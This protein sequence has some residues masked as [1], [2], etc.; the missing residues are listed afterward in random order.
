MTMYS[1]ASI[2][3]TAILLPLIGSAAVYL[4]FYIRLRLKPTFIGIDDWLILSS[5]IFVWAQ[6][7]MQVA[8]A[9]IGGLG[10]DNEYTVDLRIKKVSHA[11]LIIEKITYT[12]IKLS[13]LWFFRRIFLHQ[14]RFRIANDILIVLVTLW[15][16]AFFFTFVFLGGDINSPSQSWASLWFGITD[17]VSDVAILALPY[18]CIREL[19]MSKR[20]K[21]GVI[22]IFLLGTL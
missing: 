14:K 3:V 6:G 18:P 15:G 7:A 13:V 4:R 11:A 5:C 21:M 16:F 10:K 9:S 12:T 20:D 17:V 2:I 1:V 8:A 22:A 19:Q